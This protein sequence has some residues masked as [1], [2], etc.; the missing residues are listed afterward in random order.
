[1]VAKSILELLETNKPNANQFDFLNKK[2]IRQPKS[3]C[4][5]SLHHD[6]EGGK[7]NPDV[8]RHPPLHS[9]S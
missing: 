8:A 4:P 6:Q 2:G 5:D 3:V 1:M 7:P 9:N